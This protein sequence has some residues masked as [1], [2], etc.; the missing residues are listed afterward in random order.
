MK[1]PV[2]LRVFKN[3]QLV[4]VK[5]F[6]ADQIV[7]GHNADVQLDLSGDGVSAIHCLIERRDSGHYVCDLGSEGG[8]FKNGQAVLD[9]PLNSG[10]E[11]QIGVFKIV[12][13]VG[14]PKPKVA[15]TETA[16]PVKPAPVEAPV[17]VP[18]A[19]A[20]PERPQISEEPKVVVAPTPASPKISTP[21]VKP[22]IRSKPAKSFSRKKRG[23]TFAPVSEVKDLRDVLKPGKGNTIEVMVAWQERIIDT[24]SLKTRGQ[25]KVGST[26]RDQI[27]V[28][29]RDLPRNWTLVD[30]GK[31][32]SV[33]VSDAMG[34]EMISAQGRKKLEDCVA[35]GK[36]NRGAQGTTVRLD[37]GEMICL[38]LAGGLNIFIRYAP[39]APVVPLLPPLG[40]SGAELS[41]LTMALVLTALLAFYVSA[42]TPKDLM[43]TPQDEVTMTAQ[44]IFN[45]PPPREKTPPP[46]P[47]PPPP[48]DQK[49]PPPPPPP[50]PEKA[51]VA[52]EKRDQQK[53][54]QATNQ[55]SQRNQTAGRAAEVA[56]IPNS[57]NRPKKFTST[58]QGGAVKL[59]EQA[60]ANANS[61]KDVSKVGLF[62]AF[63]G[64][65]VRS[66]LDQAYSG[67]GELLGQAD[68]ATGAS[69]FAENRAGDD[70]GSKFKDTGAGGKGTA[71]QG[72]SGIGTKGRSSGQSAYGSVDGFGDKTSVAV[73]AGD[74]EADFVGTID[75]EAVRRRVRHYLHEIRGCYNRELNK[76][77]KGERLEGKVVISWE[78]VAQGVARN[79]RVK[80]STLGSPSVENCIRQRLASWSFPEPPVGLTAEVS[81]PFYLRPEN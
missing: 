4:E 49:P 14:V 28:N 7:I 77:E 27:R 9:E 42:T 20:I 64:G 47:P 40:L 15:P 70:L 24:F 48:P 60:G 10:D 34:F 13:F 65:G 81:F 32:V 41:G 21:P 16:E 37:Q 2:I 63:G 74:S 72:I 33:N 76:M 8:T 6:D 71:T 58:K 50:K 12:F 38:S 25:F 51:K 79:V 29:S 45:N 19:A 44:I 75:R 66:K 26:D 22:E 3:S 5:Q 17:V 53:K 61:A 57:Q 78:I 46:P 23:P 30:I 36:A 35:A 52:D 80:S 67:A 73:E 68:K 59:G 55:A 39:L 43:E 56:P 31:T 18:V 1:S 69:G 62:S 11:I 54:G